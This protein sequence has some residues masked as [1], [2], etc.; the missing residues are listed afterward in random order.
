M[1]RSLCLSMFGA[2]VLSAG[3]PAKA[4]AP[5]F[6]QPYQV[7]AGYASYAA[8]T[9]VNYG[10][11]NYVTAGNGTMV[12]SNQSVQYNGPQSQFS[13]AT[14]G[15]TTYAGYSDAQGNGGNG[16]VRFRG[17]N[18]GAAGTYQD[19]DGSSGSGRFQ[20]NSGQAVYQGG[21]GSQA[22]GQYQFNGRNGAVGGYDYD[23]SG[24]GYNGNVAWQGG[25][26]QAQGEVRQPGYI[27]GTQDRIGGGANAQ[28]RNS[29]VNGHYTVYDPT[30]HTLLGGVNGTLNRTQYNQQ[31]S[32]GLGGVRGVQ[33][34]GVNFGGVNS[35]VY[36]NQG[37]KLGGVAGYQM[38]AGGSIRG[39]NANGQFN[40][41]GARVGLGVGVNGRGVQV[42][43]T[44]PSVRVPNVSVPRINVPSVP[45]MSVPNVSTPSFGG[46]R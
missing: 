34:T 44:L 16:Y 27:P 33:N 35:Q 19:A 32:G 46:F 28:G 20:A 8:G 29:S 42:N 7:P 41:G 12:L 40:V 6:G 21:D 3:G 26:V 18:P 14:Q 22:G 45:R 11:Y 13:T 1:K 4:Q 37:A 2:A 31:Y 36:A 24:N 10:G 9:L 5:V 43:S 39:V 25:N 15:G 17:R 30:G 23:G 38:G